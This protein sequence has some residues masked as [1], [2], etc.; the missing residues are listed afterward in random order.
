MEM[1][2]WYRLNA[3]E[4]RDY[5]EDHNRHRFSTEQHL[6]GI[7]YTVIDTLWTFFCRSVLKSFS[8]F[9]GDSVL[10]LKE[11]ELKVRDCT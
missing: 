6:C 4:P 10:K 9:L 7:Y 3:C 2:S 11:Y 1:K 5:V 8:L